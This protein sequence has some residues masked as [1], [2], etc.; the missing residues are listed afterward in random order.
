MWCSSDMAKLITDHLFLFVKLIC[1]LYIVCL[2]MTRD[3][4][5]SRK[6]YINQRKRYF[7][8]LNTDHF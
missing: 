5:M 3:T 2:I 6:T 7:L 1:I 8:L 4:S